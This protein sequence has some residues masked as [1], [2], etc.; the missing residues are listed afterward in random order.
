[1]SITCLIQ[2]IFSIYYMP[3]TVFSDLASFYLVLLMMSWL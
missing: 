3:D 1:M 2:I